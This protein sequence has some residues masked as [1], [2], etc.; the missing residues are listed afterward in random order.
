M[1]EIVRSNPKSFIIAVLVH[2]VL[3][4]LL[5]FNLDWTQTTHVAPPQ[6]EIVQAVMVD[7]AKLKM[8]QK[9]KR[10]AEE[11]RRRE[12]EVQLQREA[13]QQAELKREQA[14]EQR[15]VEEAQREVEVKRAVEVRQKR[16]A[17]E[18]RVAADAER[19]RKADAEK[20]HKVE[21]E[22]Q[23]QAEADK[24][25]KQ[26]SERKAAEERKRQEAEER[27][28]EAMRRQEEI[29]ADEARLQAARQRELASERDKFIF[30]IQ[31]RVESKWRK[32]S[33]WQKGT[34]CK[35]RVRLVP[36]AG[37][38]EV[39]DVRITKSCGQKLFDQSVESAVYGASPLPFPMAPELMSEFRD[40]SFVFDPKD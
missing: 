3:F 11:R 8:A 17:E 19:K 25:R 33:G 1:F 15:R 21:E 26:E 14:A 23:R 24:K 38:A 35:V 31:Q 29:A 39:I 20:Q 16:E 12:E 6:Q 10:E 34:S 4:A 30:Q 40:F 27:Q 22:R 32:P 9:K 37:R 36:G 13:E 5:S 7:D 28:L 2:A 18:K